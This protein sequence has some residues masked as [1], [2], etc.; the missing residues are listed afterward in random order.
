MKE[1]RHHCRL[2][3]S[4]FEFIV[5]AADEQEADIFFKAGKEE[6]FRI[7]KLLTEF[8]PDSETARINAMEAHKIYTI[9]AEVYS[10][11]ERCKNFRKSLRALSISLSVH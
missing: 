1:F 8:S 11:L 4:A 10:L 6:V 9:N 3:G 5:I 2:M 7:E